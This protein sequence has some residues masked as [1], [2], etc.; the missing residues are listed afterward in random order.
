MFDFFEETLNEILP[1]PVN[2]LLFG[3]ACFAVYK[4]VNA[5]KV[6]PQSNTNNQS[7]ASTP[8][9]PNSPNNP[10]NPVIKN[11]ESTGNSFFDSISA[12]AV[13]SGKKYNIPASVIMAQAALESGWGKS[14]LTQNYNNLFGIK[15]TGP[16]GSANML[17][18]EVFGGQRVT[19]RS[20]FRAYNNLG[21]SVDGHG[22]FLTE[23]PRYQGA[24][25]AYKA[26][27]NA[28]AFA[29]D[30]AKAGYATDPIYSGKIIDLINRHNLKKYD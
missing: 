11:M 25:D 13:E 15:G 27:R 20:N 17:T 5:D 4:T 26:N 6:I 16:A 12:A 10:N 22:K 18:G 19:I 2:V 3:V 29:E 30:I 7:V 28:E 1:N 21:E 24:L 14:S 23:N 8:N 9:A